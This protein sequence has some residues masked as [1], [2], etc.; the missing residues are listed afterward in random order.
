MSSSGVGSRGSCARAIGSFLRSC[1]HVHCGCST[2]LRARSSAFEPRSPPDVR[3]YSCGP[4]V[5]ADQHI[6][7][8]R[9]YVFADTLKRTLRWKGYRVRHVINITDVGHLTSDADEGDDKLELAARRE[10]RSIWE[11]AEHYTRGFQEDLARLRIGEPDVCGRRRP[12]T[13]AQMI[14]FA[15]ALDRAGWCYALP[16]GLYFDT[17]QRRRLR[18]ARPPRRRW[19][20]RGRAGR[21]RGGQAQ[22]ERLRRVAHRPGPGEQRQ[23][24]LGLAVGAG[25]AGMAPRVLGD[26]HRAPRPPLRHPHRR[27]RPH[28]GPPHERDRPERGVPRRRRASGSGG[29]STASSSISRAPRSRSRP[30]AASSSTTWSTAAT[31]RSSTGT[32]SCRRTTAARSS[33]AG[34]RWTAPAPGSVGCSSD[35]PP[36]ASPPGGRPE[37]RRPRPPRRVRRGH[38]RRPQLRQSPRDRGRRLTRRRAVRRRPE[39][40]RRRSS[41]R[42]SPSA[43]PICRRPTST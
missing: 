21:G 13:S 1:R 23:M 36:P 4:T 31:T 15:E 28:P 11:I 32:S 42:C 3:M 43:S 38:V 33:S 30:G 22:P 41:T 12:T 7:N 20:A 10:H 19:P 35:S 18:Q 34:R 37:Q 6:G 27:R 16:S 26:V 29:G 40:A 9:A 17:S 24:E 5:Y 39:R 2:R 14:A 8:M 25:G